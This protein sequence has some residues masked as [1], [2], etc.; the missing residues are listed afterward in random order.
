LKAMGLMLEKR[1]CI[2]HIGWPI[3]EARRSRLGNSPKIL[4]RVCSLLD[5]KQIM[6]AQK[7]CVANHLR[8]KQLL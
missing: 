2:S 8:L 7:N 3:N 4:T 1:Q 6:K 5:V